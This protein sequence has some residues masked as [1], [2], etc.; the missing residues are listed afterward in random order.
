MIVT[1]FP[2]TTLSHR[3]LRKRRKAEDGSGQKDGTST[4]QRGQGGEI[5]PVPVAV[6]LQVPRHL[7]VRHSVRGLLQLQDL[8]VHTLALIWHDEIGVQRALWV[9]GLFSVWRDQSGKAAGTQEP[10]LGAPL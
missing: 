5:A 4:T 10:P 9:A 6:Q 2:G 7:P 8:E 1:L 3:Y